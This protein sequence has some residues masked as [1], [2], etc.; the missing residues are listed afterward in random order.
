VSEAPIENAARWLQP[1]DGDRDQRHSVSERYH[2]GVSRATL[3]LEPGFL[4]TAMA[5]T[6]RRRQL[7]RVSFHVK[8]LRAPT[9][10]A[11][12]CNCGVKS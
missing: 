3:R 1:A 12:S 5:C 10:A 8:R 9:S 11:I 7:Q 2:T 6:E 4:A